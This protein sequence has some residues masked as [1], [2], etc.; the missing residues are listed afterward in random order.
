MAS[1]S[2]S[3]Y[4]NALVSEGDIVKQVMIERRVWSNSASGYVRSL[5]RLLLGIISFRQICAKFSLEEL[6]FYSL[7]WSFLAY[8]VLFDFG[9]GLAVQKRT[10]EFLQHSNWRELGRML[11]SV[12]FFNCLCAVAIVGIGLVASDRLFRTIGVS[13]E[14]E[15][16]FRRAWVVFVLGVGA[17]YP[18]QTFR[19]VHYGQ[20]RIAAADWLSTG[21]GVASFI[22]LWTCLRMHWGMSWVLLGQALCMVATGIGLAISALRAMPAVVLAARDVSWG[23]LKMLARFSAHAY[24]VVF[25]SIVVLQTDRFLIGAIL[26]VTA[27]ATYHVGAKIPE[28]FSAFTWQ[29]PDAIAPAAATMHS[30][31]KREDWQR[32]FLRC[33]RLNALMTTPLFVLGFIFLEGLLGL[34]THGRAGGSEV[35]FLGRVLLVWSYSTIQTHGVS[36]SIFLMSGQER[37]LVRLLLLEALTNLI[38]SFFFLQWLR[39]P[40]GAA[41]GSLLPALAT[42][43]L[44][45]WPWAA[46]ETKMTSWSLARQALGPALRSSSPVVVFGILCHLVVGSEMQTNPAAFCGLAAFAATLA[47]WGTWSFG[48]SLDE[49]LHIM[50]KLNGYRARERQVRHWFS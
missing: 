14:N 44:L 39:R 30:Q 43:W 40:V 3:S 5:V 15:L 45:L 2:G 36:K 38:L 23:M 50:D 21:G 32:F 47:L 1:R 17:A 27:V 22:W 24:L 26:S 20:Q 37:H 16:E 11:C 35:I 13:L 28:L 31:G 18:F 6:G 25:A 29:L 10:V 42:G 46:R 48:L 8:G 33:L 19:E 4:S 12:M 34:I 49:R 7:A 41:L 9:M